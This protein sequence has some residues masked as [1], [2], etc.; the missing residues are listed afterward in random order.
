[1]NR[2]M[3]LSVTVIGVAFM[4]A[5]I[6]GVTGA[7]GPG[8]K[9]AAAGVST[10]TILS[11]PVAVRHAGG[12]F[13]SAADGAV[14]IAGDTIKTGADARAVLTYFEGSTVEMEPESELSID[15][16][17]SDANG[18]T[19]IVMQQNLGTTWHVVTHLITTGSLY[20]IH[21]S[22]ATASVR[23]TQ[24]T[25]DV[26]PDGT[27]TET[28]TEGAVA[29]TDA[30]GT[31]TVL[32]LPGERTT[33]RKGEPPSR[34]AP[35][36]QP[37]R[38]V[39]VTVGDPNAL[40]VDTLGRAN[41]LH[42]GKKILQTPGAQLRIVDGHLVVTLPDVPD[43]AIT[44]HRARGGSTD[45]SV[46]DLRTK[47]EDNGRPAVEL[48]ETVAPGTHEGVDI[49]EQADSGPSLERNTDERYASAPKVGA[50]PPAPVQAPMRSLDSR[51]ISLSSQDA[52]GPLSDRPVGQAISSSAQTFDVA[53]KVTVPVPLAPSIPRP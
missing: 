23:G 52:I 28:T 33:T 31:A 14:L 38:T 22:T 47:V 12:D 44:T 16:A 34:P 49:K 42:N 7:L 18:D 5:I 39:T 50:E 15:A 8:G 35:V 24:F 29:N 51:A 6:F 26:A 32:T 4:I 20:E 43:G 9:A 37:Q 10:L 45:G 25:V 11:G 2:R 48:A 27:T 40:V 19:I 46:T 1:M 21:T 13:A 36:P 41:G 30:Q 17:R 3:R 53:F